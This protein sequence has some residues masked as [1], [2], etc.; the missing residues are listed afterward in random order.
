MYVAFTPTCVSCA[1]NLSFLQSYTTKLSMQIKQALGHVDDDRARKLSEHSTDSYPN[2]VDT[3]VETMMVLIT[4][5]SIIENELGTSTTKSCNALAGTTAKVEVAQKE[6]EARSWSRPFYEL[7]GL[8]AVN[9]NGRDNSRGKTSLFVFELG[10]HSDTVNIGGV[11]GTR[12]LKRATATEAEVCQVPVEGPPDIGV[13]SC[14]YYLQHGHGVT[15]SCILETGQN[16]TKAWVV[17]QIDLCEDIESDTNSATI[18]LKSLMNNTIRNSE[19][20]VVA[21]WKWGET[22]GNISLAPTQK[23]NLSNI[24]LLKTSTSEFLMNASIES[25]QPSNSQQLSQGPFALASVASICSI[26]TLTGDRKQDKIDCN[27][28][29]GCEFLNETSKTN[30][31]LK[32]VWAVRTWSARTWMDKSPY[33]DVCTTD[34]DFGIEDYRIRAYASPTH[35]PN[36]DTTADYCLCR[37][38]E[39]VQKINSPLLQEHPCTYDQ[40]FGMSI[41]YGTTKEEVSGVCACTCTRAHT[42]RIPTTTL[43]TLTTLRVHA[44]AGALNFLWQLK[45]RTTYWW[46]LALY[47]VG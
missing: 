14:S 3:Q 40:N 26:Q 19:T 37:D 36:G 29:P 22:L 35:N 20:V 4:D 27:V 21:R 18:T 47:C 13:N 34:S 15:V 41:D 11:P 5:K 46:G 42:E 39:R 38:R 24:V 32:Y 1:T 45:V 44:H 33:D 8:D 31:A 6:N 12:A 28:V 30:S 17:I 7:P 43:T 10:G 16:Q 2:Q 9:I 25:G 23:L